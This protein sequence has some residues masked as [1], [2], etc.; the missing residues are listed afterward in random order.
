MPP[1][2]IDKLTPAPARPAIM[3]STPDQD[4][5][6]DQAAPT[7]TAP[8]SLA[9]LPTYKPKTPLPS[10]ANPD[11]L[12]PGA[13]QA[14]PAGSG[15]KEQTASIPAFFRQRSASYAKIAGTALRALGGYLNM[16]SGEL[17]TDAFLPDD[18]DEAT[19]P[20][21]LGRLA[22]RRVKIGADPEQLNDV[23]DIAQAAIGTLVWLVKGATTMLDA[24]RERRRIA[25]EH[26]LHTD[27]GDG[28]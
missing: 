10:A 6:Q 21:P 20:P 25:A 24:R 15:S 26:A 17:E 12:P 22:A 18:D 11:P 16:L 7:L 14:A 3:V 5:D 19:I 27:R 8:D 9:S 28:Q 1:S 13:G 23:E 2:L 4:Q